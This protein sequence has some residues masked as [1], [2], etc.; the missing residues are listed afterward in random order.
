[1]RGNTSRSL[2]VSRFGRPE[3]KVVSDSYL[4]NT[5]RVTYC[6]YVKSYFSHDVEGK[7]HGEVL[8]R[9]RFA[10]SYKAVKAVQEEGD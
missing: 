9:K 10:C 7:I 2:L 4:S 6:V 5:N 3:S 8:D 1:M